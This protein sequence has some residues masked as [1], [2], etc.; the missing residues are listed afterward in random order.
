[1]TQILKTCFLFIS[2][3]S[4]VALSGCGGSGTPAVKSEEAAVTN[5][6]APARSTQAPETTPT[7]TVA[8]K[9]ETTAGASHEASGSLVNTP[10]AK[11]KGATSAGTMKAE[12]QTAQAGSTGTSAA[13]AKEIAAAPPRKMLTLAE[14]KKI[15]FELDQ[16]LS[17][18]SNKAGDTFTGT[19]TAPLLMNQGQTLAIPAGAK[20]EGSVLESESAKRIKGQARLALK[21]ESIVLSSG[22]RIPLTASLREQADST[23]KRDTATIAGGAAAGAILGAIAGKGAKGAVIGAVAGGAIGTGVVLGTKGKEVD[24]PLGTELVIELD[25]A[26]EI[27][28]PTP[29]SQG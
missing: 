2:V 27:P 21:F 25:Q 3:V 26:V 8:G 1:M 5:G 29:A 19:L 4:L 12:P 24:M 11:P 10:A 23:K 22:E 9:D 15:R 16:A 18:A 14:G 6:S 13:P 7:A 20:I 28:D 17:S